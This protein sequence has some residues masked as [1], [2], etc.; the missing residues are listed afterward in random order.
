[1][2]GAGSGIGAGP[3]SV[4]FFVTA[5]VVVTGVSSNVTNEG[6]GTC[7]AAAH[8]TSAADTIADKYDG[9]EE[10]AMDT[11]RCT[12]LA[13]RVCVARKGRNNERKAAAAAVQV[14][15]TACWTC[16]PQFAK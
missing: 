5:A 1:M 6:E 16:C 14:R 3:L 7:T 15:T 9:M 8:I 4:F 11:P 13:G 2:L 12:E 10:A